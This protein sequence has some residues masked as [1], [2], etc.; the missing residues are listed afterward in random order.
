MTDVQFELFSGPEHQVIR[1]ELETLVTLVF[2]R[3]LLDYQAHEQFIRIAKE[4]GYQRNGGDTAIVNDLTRY[5][6]VKLLF[7]ANVSLRQGLRRF[8]RDRGSISLD[9]WPAQE[10]ILVGNEEDQIAYWRNRWSEAGGREVLGRM[11]ALKNDA[12]WQRLSVYNL[13]FPPFD[14]PSYN[15]AV[16]EIR[17]DEAENLLPQEFVN[18]PATT[19]PNE[20]PLYWFDEAPANP[21]DGT[22]HALNEYFSEEIRVYE[23][24][25][26]PE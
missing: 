18:P 9:C 14:F 20:L 19:V 6:R 26:R 16:E 24:G 13:P 23:G 2:E 22:F 8:H 15:D 21:R 4:L 7:D 12:I 10:L 11:V 5:S 1:K 17:G 3:T 25:W